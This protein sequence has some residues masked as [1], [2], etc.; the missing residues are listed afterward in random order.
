MSEFELD[1]SQVDSV[2]LLDYEGAGPVLEL[3]VVGE[4]LFLSIKDKSDAEQYS[5]TRQIGVNLNTLER[6]IAYACTDDELLRNR[7][8]LPEWK[9]KEIENSIWVKP[10]S[11]VV[12]ASAAKRPSWDEYAITLARAAAT[13]SEDPYVKVGAVTLRKDRSVASLGYN[14]APSGV[15]LDWSD[16][17]ERRKRVLHAEANA[18]RYIRPGELEGGLLATTMVPCLECLKAA[19][20]QGVTEIV[21]AEDITDNY[22]VDEIFKIAHEFGVTLRRLN[23]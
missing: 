17:D 20:A 11:L 15:E 18:L 14:G 5:E 9:D 19:R 4:I 3:A 8:N 23:A 2:L 22:D 21:F 16:R 10:A 1:Y 7:L 12:N 13:R 6:A